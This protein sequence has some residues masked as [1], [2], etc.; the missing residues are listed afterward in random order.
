MIHK[1]LAGF[2]D[3][4]QLAGDEL[5]LEAAISLGDWVD[6]R[7]GRL[8]YAHMQQVLETEYG[9]LPEALANLYTITGEQR[10]LL[11]ARAVL[12]R[13]GA[14]P[15]GRRPGPAA[16]ALHANISV[17]KVISCLRLWEETGTDLYRRVAVNFWQMVAA[18]PHL[19]HR[20]GQQLRAFPRSRGSSPGSCPTT[21]ARTVS[22]TTC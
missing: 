5:A 8:S 13:P 9:G 18:A 22:A 10:Y 19:R 6:W 4:Y 14:G 16:T 3:Q 11:A 12:P 20:R 2:I 1:Y 15:D 17:P 7:S 21:P